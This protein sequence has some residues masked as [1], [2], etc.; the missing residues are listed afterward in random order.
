VSPSY[1]FIP[2][3]VDTFDGHDVGV[4]VD[5]QGNAYG[6]EVDPPTVGKYVKK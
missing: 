5:K 1:E 6:A 4:A 3:I 2:V